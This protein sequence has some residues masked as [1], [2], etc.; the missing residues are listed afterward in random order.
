MPRIQPLTLETAQDD[1]KAVLENVQQKLG[2]VPNIFATLAHSPAAAGAFFGIK[3]ALAGGTIPAKLG[4]QI[5]LAVGNAN[6]CEYCVS[7]HTAIGKMNGLTQE[8]TQ[9][10][11]RGQAS[12]AKDQAALV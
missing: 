8:Q 4:E 10:A 6:S 7:A 1:S 5:A 3:E 2:Q 9:A 12:D 11:Q